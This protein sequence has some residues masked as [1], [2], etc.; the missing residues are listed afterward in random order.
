[1]NNM[2]T[3]KDLEFIEHPNHIGGIRASI[4][5]ENGEML[6]YERASFVTAKNEETWQII[7]TKGSLDLDLLPRNQKKIT[8]HKAS[9][10][11]SIAE[12]IWEGQETWDQILGGPIVDF[13]QAILEGRSPKTGLKESLMIQQII[14]GIYQSRSKMTI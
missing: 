8:F 12:V 13:A 7:G 2:K 3:F 9:P 5:F 14:D 4:M 1:M 11:G 10:E 6:Q